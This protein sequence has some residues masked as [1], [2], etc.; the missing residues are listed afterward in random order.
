LHF[1]KVS[2]NLGNL[3]GGSYPFR[4][5]VKEWPRNGPERE[6]PM[7][8][9]K[10]AVLA[11]AA[12]VT[13]GAQADDLLLIDLSVVNQITITATAGNSAATVS[14]SSFTGVLLADFYAGAG[15]ALT[16]TLDAGDLTT[17]ANASDG[18]PAL[19]RGGAGSNVGLN[20]WSYASDGGS[21][22]TAGS[23]AFTGSATWNI[24][25]A[26]YADMLAGAGSGDI[27]A[28]ADTDD[29]IP[30][31]VVIGTYNVVPAPSAMAV[32]GLGG[33]VAGRRRR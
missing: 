21:D 33:L 19:F 23:L 6:N 29:D 4:L 9:I 3:V 30:S 25:A 12:I 26:M 14:G 22:F 28:P 5:S 31:A 20:I 1:Q 7:S 2:I 15:S 10:M 13:T 17:A 11:S 24:D 32:L 27:Y 8:A 16:A 18:S